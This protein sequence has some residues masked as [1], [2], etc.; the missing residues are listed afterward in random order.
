[1]WCSLPAGT[2]AKGFC[3]N[4]DREIGVSED[5]TLGAPVALQ[6][7]GWSGVAFF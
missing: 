6:A 3:F 1:V 2:E 4:P 7:S 5:G